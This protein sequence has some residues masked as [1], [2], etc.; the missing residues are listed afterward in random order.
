MDEAIK[1][2]RRAFFAFGAI[3][4]FQGQLNPISGRSIYETCV[5]PVLW[6]GC[7]NLVLTDSMLHQLES[8]QE[9]FG[10]QILKL[11]RHHSILSTRLALRWPSVTARVLISK[12]S[13]LSKLNEGGG[14]IG[15][16]IISSLPQGSLRLVRNDT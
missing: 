9:D 10:R 1:K 15:S 5:I 14:S 3:G 6:F 4:A 2:A 11:S 7:E 13:L 16:Q 12:L 8:F